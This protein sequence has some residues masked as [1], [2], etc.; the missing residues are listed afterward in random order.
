MCYL[1]TTDTCNLHCDHCFTNGHNGKKGWFDVPRTIDFFKRLHQ[2]TPIVSS[3]TISFHG[4]EPMLA[5][6]ELI[7]ELYDGVKGLWDNLGWTIQTNLTYPITHKK[8]EIFEVICG[9]SWGTSWDLN[10]R[11][12]NPKQEQLWRDNVKTLSAQGHDITVMVCLSGDVI[13]TLQPIDIINDM[14]GLGIKHI[15]FERVTPNGNA[16][17]FMDVGILPSNVELD[18]W[19]LLMWEQMLEHKTWE[20]VDNMFFDSILTG[21]IYN[22]HDGYRCRDCEQKILTIN[23]DGTIGGCPNSATDN[24]F[25]TINDDIESLMTSEGRMCNIASELI[26]HPKCSICP[27]FDICNG[28]CHQL[29]FQG[30]VCAS[31]KSTM[32]Q[33]KNK[34]DIPLYNTILDGAKNDNRST[35][36]V[37]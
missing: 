30:N 33:I 13:R 5:P 26:R 10:I 1:K 34:S 6:P 3:G 36:H 11:W 24:T 35:L 20:Y 28:D 22:T 4:G 15:N 17:K 37:E 7:F 8:I 18:K 14:V 16:L 27:V 32:I 19:L 29:S 25:G 31:P 2:Y 23:A 12:P 9:K 21:M